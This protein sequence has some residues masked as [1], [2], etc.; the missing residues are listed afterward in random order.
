MALF[1]LQIALSFLFA[2]TA[3]AQPPKIIVG[4][5]ADGHYLNARVVAKHIG[6]QVQIVPGGAGLNAANYFYNVSARDGSEIGTFPSRV[7]LS[8]LVDDPHAKYNLAKMHWLGSFADGRQSPNIV[9]TKSGKDLIV[10]SE[11]SVLISPIK[12]I[13]HVLRLKIPE[14]TGYADAP[15]VRLAFER[16]EITAVVFNLTGVKISSPHWIGSPQVRPILQYNS[17]YT[18]HVEFKDVP[19]VMERIADGDKK[20]LFALFELHGALVR[21]YA[22]PPNVASNKVIEWKVR[23][24]KLMSD[25]S[26]IKDAQKIGLE[27]T[28]VSADEAQQIAA[29]I[30]KADINLKTSLRSL[31]SR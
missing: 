3:A 10:G 26:Y 14:V 23:F 7:F 20:R 17:G 4:S 18:R 15:S 12:V 22:L 27:V 25:E 13:T 29:Q 30:T 8:A 5:G 16:D 28:P 19:A 31:A 24:A 2:S 6:A 9:W 21:P 11:G 1:R